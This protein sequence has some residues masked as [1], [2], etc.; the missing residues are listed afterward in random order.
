ME[1]STASAPQ[2]KLKSNSFSFFNLKF[3]IFTTVTT[4]GIFTVTVGG[5]T[6]SQTSKSKAKSSAVN[7]PSPR[8]KPGLAVCKGTLY[9]YGGEYEEGSKQYTLNDFYSLGE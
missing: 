9:L 3:F 4:D 1:A 7:V 5:S 8:M 6:A 2:G